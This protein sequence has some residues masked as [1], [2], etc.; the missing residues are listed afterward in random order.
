[1]FQDHG[2]TGDPDSKSSGIWCI[3]HGSLVGCRDIKAFCYQSISIEPIGFVERGKIFLV[4]G[5]QEIFGANDTGLC[6][7]LYGGYIGIRPEG[8]LSVFVDGLRIGG[9]AGSK[10]VEALPE[11]AI[12]GPVCGPGANC[13]HGNEVN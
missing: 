12:V 8:F 4:N 7:I 10:E 6:R 3:F 13:A 1:M 5:V 9:T 11:Q 2:N